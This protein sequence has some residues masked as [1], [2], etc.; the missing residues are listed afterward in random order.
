[1]SCRHL[2]MGAYR[3]SG[4]AEAGLGA[5]ANGLELSARPHARQIGVGHDLLSSIELGMGVHVG[6]KVPTTKSQSGRA[7]CALERRL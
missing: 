6:P 2:H 1:M 5:D 4:P 7:Y 3:P